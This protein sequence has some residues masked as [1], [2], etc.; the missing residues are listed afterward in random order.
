MAD[1]RRIHLDDPIGGA[2][3]TVKSPVLARL[4]AA[5]LAVRARMDAAAG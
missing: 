1:L 3:G 5:Y 2:N 4:T